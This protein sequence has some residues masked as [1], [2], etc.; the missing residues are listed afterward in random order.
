VFHLDIIVGIGDY[1]ISNKR[2]DVI[3]TYALASCVGVTLY[4]PRN[5]VA[6]MLHTV[7]PDHHLVNSSITNPSYFVSTGVPLLLNRLEKEFGCK[8]RDLIIRLYGG[9]N[10]INQSDLFHIGKKNLN[11]ITH[12]LTDLNLK[13]TF[14]DVGGNESRT[15]EIK[16]ASGDVKVFKQP[17]KI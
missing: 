3:K 7:L 9:A 14:S 1:A 11:A 16:V 17:I 8:K 5:G 13:Y 15:I 6:A 10:S 4:C 12:L 2:E